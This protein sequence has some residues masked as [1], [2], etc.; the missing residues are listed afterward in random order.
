M[1]LTTQS[2]YTQPAIQRPV[3]GGS[4]TGFGRPP[5]TTVSS[6]P[7]FGGAPM[8]PTVTAMNPLVPTA[9]SV[10]QPTAT[11]TAAKPGAKFDDLW[12]LSLGTGTTRPASAGAGG[13]SI[14]DLEREKATAGLWGGSGSAVKPMPFGSMGGARMGSGLG[15]ASSS[16]SNNASGTDD[17]LL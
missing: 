14:K 2:P 13:K 12:S 17:L 15:G 7:A 10:V 8:M 16:V 1:P 6:Q 3:F 5:A 4:S 9:R 11:T